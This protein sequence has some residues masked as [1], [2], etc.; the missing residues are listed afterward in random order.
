LAIA[1]LIIGQTVLILRQCR[2][3][4]QQRKGQVM[5]IKRIL[6]SL[7]VAAVLLGVA[8]AVGAQP[9][10]PYPIGEVTIESQQ[11]AAGVGIT[12]GDGTLKFKG[13]EYKFTVR[14]LDAGAVGISKISAKGDVYN[15]EKV[16]D[17]AGNYAV[18]QA[19]ATVYKGGTGLLMRN[20]KGVV[21]NMKAAQKGVQLSLG[22]QGLSISMKK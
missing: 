15:L 13:K 4:Y 17:F 18:A 9:Q 10:D 7:A 11:I 19:G 14:G 12:W 1:C 21:I 8:Y 5:G 20:T 2:K 3:I 22:A 16:E 6:C